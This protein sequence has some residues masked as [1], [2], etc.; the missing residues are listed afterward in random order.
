MRGFYRASIAVIVMLTMVA[1]VWPQNKAVIQHNPERQTTADIYSDYAP[2]GLTSVARN[3]RAAAVYIS[4]VKNNGNQGMGSG[5]YGIYKGYPVI[6]TAAHVVS[7][8]STII[9]SSYNGEMEAGRLAYLDEEADLAVLYVEPM[10]SLPQQR[11]GLLTIYGNVAGYSYNRMILHSYA[12]M[13][14][15]GSGVYDKSGNL[16][17]VVS[18]ISIGRW[19]MPQLI[20]DVVYVAPIYYMNETVLQAALEVIHDDT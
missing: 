11:F 3:S 16:V 17:G 15:S 9:V 4:V 6:I 18:A 7:D 2:V 19:I 20:E 5:T 14:A 10:R 1:L 8:C 12:W 13:G